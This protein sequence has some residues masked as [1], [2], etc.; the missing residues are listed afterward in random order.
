MHRREERTTALPSSL[1]Y[2]FDQL[3]CKYGMKAG[4]EI[5]LLP[6]MV[7]AKREWIFLTKEYGVMRH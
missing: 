2:E 4:A 6:F 5:P 7:N 1:L 3:D